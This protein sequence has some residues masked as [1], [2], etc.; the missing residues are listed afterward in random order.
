MKLATD[1]MA[2][3]LSEEEFDILSEAEAKV[4][5]AE[6]ALM[7]ARNEASAMSL[8][9]YIAGR[10]KQDHTVYSRLSYK[11]TSLVTE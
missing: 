7:A 8:R 11:Y 4:K 5:A 9:Y 10:V 2:Q 1:A 6:E 3:A